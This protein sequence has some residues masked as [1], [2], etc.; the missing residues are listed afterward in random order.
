[1]LA[2]GMRENSTTCGIPMIHPEKNKFCIQ[3]DK[4]VISALIFTC[5]V[6][7][8]EVAYIH[9]LEVGV[10]FFINRLVD[11]IFVF[12]LA[13]QF[14]LMYPVHS[15]K[16]TIW[17]SIPGLVAKNYLRRWFIVDVTSIMPFDTAAMIVQGSVSGSKSGLHQLRILKVIRGLR[18]LKLMRI[19]RASRILKR[20]QSNFS[21]SQQRLQMLKFMCV[22]MVAAHWMACAWGLAG[23]LGEDDGV[24]WTLIEREKGFETPF[25][26]WVASL[27]WSVMTLTSIGYGDISPVTTQ[28]R[29]VCV[30]LMLI[31]GC[32]WA[33]LIGGFTAI[34]TS[35]DQRRLEF[36]TFVDELNQVM[37]ASHLPQQLRVKLRQYFYERFEVGGTPKRLLE[38]VEQ[39]SPSLMKEVVLTVSVS[40]M[41]EVKWLDDCSDEFKFAVGK[42]LEIATYAPAESFGEIW[43]LYVLHYGVAARKA[44][45][46]F[47]FRGSVWGEDC[48]IDVMDLLENPCCMAVTYCEVLTLSK[49]TLCD[50]ASEHPGDERLIRAYCARLTARRA[51]LRYAHTLTPEPH[52]HG[53]RFPALNQ[54]IKMLFNPAQLVK[55]PKKRPNLQ[56]VSF[57]SSVAEIQSCI[58]VGGTVTEPTT[59]Y[60]NQPEV[61]PVENILPGLPEDEDACQEEEQL[62]L[63][64]E[65][66]IGRINGELLAQGSLLKDLEQSMKSTPL[67]DALKDHATQHI[68]YLEA[69]KPEGQVCSPASLRGPFAGSPNPQV[70]SNSHLNTPLDNS[71]DATAEWPA[72]GEAWS[73]EGCQ[74]GPIPVCCRSKAGPERRRY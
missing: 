62:L 11:A 25:E 58:S 61:E 32:L 1:M 6:T 13:L 52:L 28:E 7:P 26:L 51:V 41:Q 31:A 15:R 63:Q 18:L 53:L 44:R 24:A 57:L 34:A 5:T 12:D 74:E 29:V 64:I 19:L 42:C 70:I 17:V 10:L 40:W 66:R 43:T 65:E 8:Y 14:F 56:Q 22:L 38:L 16:G 21:M 27:H 33:N 68:P 9:N 73:A 39:M 72:E 4:V 36:N 50:L 69:P 46:S 48:V 49:P 60:L 2:L 47:L 55:L 3:W 45:F 71:N 54:R 37:D 20:W 67:L 30:M 35:L 59:P 23:A